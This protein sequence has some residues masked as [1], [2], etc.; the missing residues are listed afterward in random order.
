MSFLLLLVVRGLAGGALVVCFALISEV[1]SPK[2][3]SGLFSAA[4]SVAFA[5]LVLTASLESTSKAWLEVVGMV[6]GGIAMVAACAAAV[7]L[8]P[9]ARALVTCLAACL[10]WALVALGLYW[11]VVLGGH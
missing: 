9:R 5:S 7:V 6:I 4:P 1:V 8:I 10:T 3:F 11:T 2:A